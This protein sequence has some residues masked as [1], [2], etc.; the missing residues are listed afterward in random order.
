LLPS[1]YASVAEIKLMMDN[2][3]D[4]SLTTDS[5][6][7]VSTNS[8]IAVTAHYITRDFQIGSC[9]LECFK[10]S[11]RHTAE[12]LSNELLR[13]AREW[14]N[15]DKVAVVITDNAANILVAIRQAGFKHLRC[16]A[17]TLNSS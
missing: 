3:E 5:W 10:N 16:F 15:V 13:V 2:A 4:V 12:I 17:H 9:L 14:G 7:S 1:V 11:K 8:C 6:T